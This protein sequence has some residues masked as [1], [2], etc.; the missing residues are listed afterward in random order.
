MKKTTSKPVLIVAALA[1][2]LLLYWGKAVLAPLAL[3]ILFTLILTPFAS[4]L[5]RHIGR[6]GSVLVSCLIALVASALILVSVAK[7][8]STLSHALPRSLDAILT[9]ANS[10]LPSNDA[11]NQLKTVTERFLKD[12]VEPAQNGVSAEPLVVQLQPDHFQRAV[13]VVSLVGGQLG[14]IGIV[15]ILMMF[16][17]YDRERLNERIVRAVGGG[18]LNVTTQALSDAQTRISRFLLAQL[19]A[20]I[21]FATVTGIGLFLIGLPNAFSWSVLS[22]F[23]R[24]IPYAGVWIAAA[25]PLILAAGGGG[26]DFFY[27][28]ALY[29]CVE[30]ILVGFVEPVWL[31]SSA[32]ISPVALILSAVFWTSVWGFAGLLLSTPMT[33]CLMVLGKYIPYFKV[34]DTLLS[35]EVRIDPAWRYYQRLLTQNIVSTQEFIRGELQQR[36]P[37]QVLDDTVLPALR[38]FERDRHRGALSYEREQSVPAAFTHLADELPELLLLPP[39]KDKLPQSINLSQREFSRLPSG[40]VV[41]IPARDEADAS[42]A[43]MYCAIQQAMGIP[44][45]ALS[46]TA[47]ASEALKLIDESNA[48]I[49]CISAVPPHGAAHVR[50]LIKRI[51]QRHPNVPIQVCLWSA[52]PASARLKRRLGCSENDQVVHSIGEG[53]KTLSPLLSSLAIQYKPT[54][55]A[56]LTEREIPTKNVVVLG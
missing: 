21:V 44:A 14:V 51:R 40:C 36:D 50:Y 28:L 7:Q 52:K 55:S 35:S 12:A 1:A 54:P 29:A 25:V 9:N 41:C 45:T 26:P 46:N 38:L 24:F 4:R 42:A 23:L 3:A 18:E 17:L 56:A 43:R 5:E 10:V 53:L 2:I 22:V 13:D 32:G 37:L 34:F 39:I 31:G 6:V 11:L 16:M 49:V 20:N 48:E 33:A 30:V 19:M 47:L 15:F 8:V 27:L